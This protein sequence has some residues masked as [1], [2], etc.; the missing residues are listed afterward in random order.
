MADR[1]LRRMNRTELIEIIFALKQS[2]DA[3]K[4]ENAALTAQLEDRQIHLR[5]AGS[6]ARASLELNHVFEAAQSAADDYLASVQSILHEARDIRARARTEAQQILA[7]AQAEAE[8]LKADTEAE[9]RALRAAAEPKEPP[10][11]S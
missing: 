9:C 3:L 6:I 10:E 11:E 4:A 1:E 5:H 7:Q 2:E 8:K